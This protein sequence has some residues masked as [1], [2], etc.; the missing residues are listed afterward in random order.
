MFW[1]LPEAYPDANAAWQAFE[2]AL[3]AQRGIVLYRPAYES[4]LY[5]VLQEFMEDNVLYLEFRGTLTPVSLCLVL[6]YR[7]VYDIYFEI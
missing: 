1:S 2:D 3:D 4:Y 7:F 5:Q 6:L